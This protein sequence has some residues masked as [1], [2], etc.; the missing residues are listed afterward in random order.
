MMS[1]LEHLNYD[2]KMAAQDKF[3]IKE[4]VI[5]IESFV[6]GCKILRI[7]S[8]QH[9]FHNECGKKWFDSKTQEN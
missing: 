3:D 7:P 1:C 9:F 6:E 2:S 5:C 8:C 4:C